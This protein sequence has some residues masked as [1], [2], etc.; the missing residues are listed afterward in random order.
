MG[1]NRS[2]IEKSVADSR[3]RLR[4][5]RWPIITGFHTSHVARYDFIFLLTFLLFYFFIFL[6]LYLN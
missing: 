4:G 1:V 6:L 2:L 3:D 5:L